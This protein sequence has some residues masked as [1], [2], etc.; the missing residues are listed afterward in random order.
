MV[1]VQKNGKASTLD[2]VQGE[3]QLVER[4]KPTLPAGLNIQTLADQS[5]FVT[6]AIEGVVKEAVIAGSRRLK[7]FAIEMSYIG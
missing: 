4:L 6:A 2:I 1:Q 5:I 7:Q 3:K